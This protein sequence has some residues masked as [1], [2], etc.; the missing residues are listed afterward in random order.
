MAVPLGTTSCM[1]PEHARGGVVDPRSDIFS[2][3]VVLYELLSGRR[4]FAGQTAADTMAAVLQCDPAPLDLPSNRGQDL[5]RI[6]TN[7]L[8]KDPARRY[9]DAGALAEDLRRFQ[10]GEPICARPVGRRERAAK[11][12]RR[13]PAVAALLGTVGVLLLAGVSLASGLAAWALGE[14]RR[15]D[16][17]AAAALAQAARA[18]LAADNAGQEAKF[19]RAQER[20]AV[21]R[22]E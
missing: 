8:E 21:H 5:P 9:G 3:G 22:D 15:A 6:V 17:E 20:L 1:A 19:G 14:A 10:A 7:C 18:D 4:P 16:S 2:A 12:V 13:N 11:W